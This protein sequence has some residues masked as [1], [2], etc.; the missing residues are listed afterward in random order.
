MLLFISNVHF[1]IL[2]HLLVNHAVA[3]MLHHALESGVTKTEAYQLMAECP[4]DVLVMAAG[5]IRDMT[6]P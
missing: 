2:L 5:R 6:R 4:T 3:E 1:P